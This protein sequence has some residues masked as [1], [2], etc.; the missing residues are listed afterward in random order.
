MIHMDCDMFKEIR[1]ETEYKCPN[2]KNLDPELG[3]LKPKRIGVAYSWIIELM[4]NALFKKCICY[5]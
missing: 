3:R 4:N 1:K 2:C 5:R